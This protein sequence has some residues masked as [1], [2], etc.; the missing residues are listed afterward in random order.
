MP[1]EAMARLI[2]SG[3]LPS[4]PHRKA[5]LTEDIDDA[6]IGYTF[7]A[8]DGGVVRSFHYWTLNM[9]RRR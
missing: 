2:I 1:V 5:L 8:Q 4:P 9:G 7:I 6:G 3:S